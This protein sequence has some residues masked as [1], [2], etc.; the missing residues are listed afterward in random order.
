MCEIEIYGDFMDGSDI[1]DWERK[2]RLTM[3]FILSERKVF[4][5]D[6]EFMKL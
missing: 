6:W 3:N 2:A 4:S 1:S 5:I